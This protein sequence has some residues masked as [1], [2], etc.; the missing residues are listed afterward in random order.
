MASALVSS[1]SFSFSSTISKL[2]VFYIPIITFYVGRARLTMFLD[3]DIKRRPSPVFRS[4][5]IST[6][7]LAPKQQQEDLTKG[8]MPIGAQIKTIRLC[9]ILEAPSTENKRSCFC[10][11]NSAIWTRFRLIDSFAC[12]RENDIEKFPLILL[13]ESL[14][15]ISWDAREWRRRCRRAI[16]IM[17]DCFHCCFVLL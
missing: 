12:H 17:K 14:F 16:V 13:L 10:M 15:Y 11:R 9:Q 5:V 1:S 2:N 3:T 6:R 8:L 7:S 4:H